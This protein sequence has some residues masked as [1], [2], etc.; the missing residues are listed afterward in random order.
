MSD[1]LDDLHEISALRQECQRL[2]HALVGMFRWQ[3]E[4]VNELMP[5]LLWEEV[6][7]CLGDAKINEVLGLDAKENTP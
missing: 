1:G 6:R 3:A 2:R 4:S 7:E 5:D